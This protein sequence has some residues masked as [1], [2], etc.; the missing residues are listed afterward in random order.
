MH[1]F[2]K[3]FNSV[4]AISGTD[5]DNHLYINKIN[6]NDKM[7]SNTMFSSQKHDIILKI[8][9]KQNN[10]NTYSLKRRH[11]PHKHTNVDLYII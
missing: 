10:G 8:K 6:M 3:S 2:Y 7:F 9:T 5:S 11:N 4:P 1:L